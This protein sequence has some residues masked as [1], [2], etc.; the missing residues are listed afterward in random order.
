MARS[1]RNSKPA[2]A[3]ATPRA[4]PSPKTSADTPPRRRRIAIACQGG[5]SQT[6][7]TAG[8]L[9]ALLRAGVHRDF[10][11]VT[12]TGTSGGAICAAL[13]WYALRR[14]EPEPW[15][16]LEAFWA[17]NTAQSPQERA[18]NDSLVES[19]RTVSR[20]HLPIFQTSPAMPV[21]Q[22]MSRT[23][24]AFFRPEFTDL[25][26]LLEKHIDFAE[27]AAWGAG[28]A[29]PNLLL[30]AIDILSG[31]LRVFHSRHD[32]ISAAHIRASC[33][34]PNLFPAVEVDGCHYWDG[35]F[36]DNPPIAEV[37]REH[38]VGREN[39]PDEIWIIKINPTRAKTVPSEPE[40]VAD[41]RN[42]LIGNVSLFQQ[43]HSIEWLNQLF[44]RGAFSP[45]FTAGLG[46]TRPIRL[47][48]AYAHEPVAAW[49]IP[50]IAISEALQG[51]LD[52]ESKLDRS[53]GNIGALM[54][55]GVSQAQAFLAERAAI[56]TGF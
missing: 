34:V 50:F 15:K 11:I 56:Q 3:A 44:D 43:L 9:G 7:F 37:I 21:M 48:R 1:V 2:A 32:A 55:D 35:L 54:A 23:T 28:P 13:V 25:Q 30:G 33:A 42:E 46:I 38:Y 20:G 19:L 8:A 36:S 49:H 52:Y 29:T 16:R 14:G 31:D 26:L 47:P 6:A 18:F 41:R 53:P 27:V 22:L 5:G 45:D 51:K 12:L 17:A 40:A 24:S 39:F 10:D 4:T